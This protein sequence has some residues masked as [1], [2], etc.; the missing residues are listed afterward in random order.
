MYVEIKKECADDVTKAVL[1]IDFGKFNQPE[2]GAVQDLII[3]F[4][5]Y[6]PEEECVV[7]EF[8]H[9]LILSTDK[10]PAKQSAAMTLASLKIFLSENSDK[11]SSLSE[12]YIISDTGP[13]T[14]QGLIFYVLL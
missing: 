5:F 1:S 14:F 7:T 13:S 11:L 2:E 10:S 3:A 8:Y 6:S 9:N 12:L 4:T